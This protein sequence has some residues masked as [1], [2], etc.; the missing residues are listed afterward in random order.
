MERKLPFPCGVFGVEEELG[1]GGFPAQRRNIA[2]P[3]L[4]ERIFSD[5][6]KNAIGVVFAGK[7]AFPMV[8]KRVEPEIPQNR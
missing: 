3:G 1:E 8:G 6:G 4:E 2:L 5:A 7:R